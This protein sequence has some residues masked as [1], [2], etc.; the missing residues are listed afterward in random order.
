MNKSDEGISDRLYLFDYK[1]QAS[2]YGLTAVVSSSGGWTR[3]LP[4]VTG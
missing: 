2:A 4:N 3:G 1:F